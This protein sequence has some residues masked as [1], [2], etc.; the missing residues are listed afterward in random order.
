MAANTT[1]PPRE[2]SDELNSRLSGFRSLMTATPPSSPPRTQ[3]NT[4][5]QR[6]IT[7]VDGVTPTALSADANPFVPQKYEQPSSQTSSQPTTPSQQPVTVQT[8][9]QQQQQFYYVQQPQYVV[10]P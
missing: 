3:P 8:T 4:P 9:P 5:V 6:A 2:Q 10:Q 1:S 7:P